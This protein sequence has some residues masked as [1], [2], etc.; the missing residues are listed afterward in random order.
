MSGGQ[1]GIGCNQ[2]LTVLHQ[3][4]AEYASWIIERQQQI[5]NVRRRIP[6][7]ESR[8]ARCKNELEQI[9]E[10]HRGGLPG[11][12]INCRNTLI[13]TQ[14]RISDV[15]RLVRRHESTWE[16]C[17]QRREILKTQN[18][19]AASNGEEERYDDVESTVGTSNGSADFPSIASK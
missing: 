11:T 10:R 5:Q 6:I 2:S 15:R 13:A 17:Q 18:A 4:I 8:S 7:E 14:Q 19:T 9:I 12:L 3:K 1:N 16:V